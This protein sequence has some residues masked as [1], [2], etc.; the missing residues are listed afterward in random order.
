LD[1]IHVSSY[2]WSAG[3]A[4]FGSDQAE[5]ERFSRERLLRILLGQRAVD[6]VYP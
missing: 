2:V 5:V 1:V 4:F 3:R 6:L